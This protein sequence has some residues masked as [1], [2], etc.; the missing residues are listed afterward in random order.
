MLCWRKMA[1]KLHEKGRLAVKWS[2]LL[3]KLQCSTK[4][5]GPMPQYYDWR[6]TSR[7]NAVA[8]SSAIFEGKWKSLQE[9]KKNLSIGSYWYYC[10]VVLKGINQRLQLFTQARKDVSRSKNT[11]FGPFSFFPT[12]A[13]VFLYLSA[14]RTPHCL[15]MS[16]VTWDCVINE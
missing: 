3:K 8:K 6:H 10:I 7:S 1:L 15:D 16:T 11:P 4:A 13:V 5:D 14:K 12:A 2:Q 9:K